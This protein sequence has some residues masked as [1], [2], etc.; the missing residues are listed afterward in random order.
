MSK[1][2]NAIRH[3]GV[4]FY[5]MICNAKDLSPD[6]KAVIETLLGRR[7]QED[8]A[9]SVRTFEPVTV[10]HRRRLEIANE[11]RKYFAEVD[12]ARQP[13]SEEEAEDIITEAMRSVRPGYR[14]RQ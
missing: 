10:S 11:L 12:A 5:R 14:P 7:I 2:W 9:V 1:S 13:V 3:N 4:R 8:E 6:Q